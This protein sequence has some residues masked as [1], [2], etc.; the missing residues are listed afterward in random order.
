MD[1]HVPLAITEALRVRGIDVLTAQEDDARQLE[2]HE[3]LDRAGSLGR[4]LFTRD[5]DLLAEATRRQRDG[6]SF[7]GVIFAHQ[8]QVTIGQCVRDLELIAA[9]G[10]PEDLASQVCFL[11]LR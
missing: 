10:E 9:A 7:R 2:D 11:P 8:L 4:V 1:V 3:L 6:V 5:V